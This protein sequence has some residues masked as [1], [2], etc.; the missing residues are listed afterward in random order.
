MNKKCDF[1]VKNIVSLCVLILIVLIILLR[2]QKKVFSGIRR[3]CVKYMETYDVKHAFKKCKGDYISW[4]KNCRKKWNLEYIVWSAVEEFLPDSKGISY[5]CWI[6]QNGLQEI[7]HNENQANFSEDLSFCGLSCAFRKKKKAYEKAPYSIE[8]RLSFEEQLYL[9]FDFTNY[10]DLT[11]KEIT[12]VCFI[13][14]EDG[15]SPLQ[16]KSGLV[17]HEDCYAESGET[18]SGRA[19]LEKYS[20]FNADVLYEVDFVYISRI[21]YDD[22]SEWTDPY[23]LRYFNSVPI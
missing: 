11:A 18:F 6:G 8:A 16:G 7:Y 23:G 15:N 3:V 10:S 12:I 22:G 2:P 4:Q 20:D 14:D 9:D 19:A 21:V 13:Y 5:G 1:T 17:V